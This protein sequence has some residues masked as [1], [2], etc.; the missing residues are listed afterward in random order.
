MQPDNSGERGYINVHWEEEKPLYY[1]SL[2][3]LTQEFGA[4]TAIGSSRGTEGRRAGYEMREVSSKGNLVSSLNSARSN[5][6]HRAQSFP[7]SNSGF[8]GPPENTGVSCSSALQILYK[9]LSLANSRPEQY[10]D[11]N[12]DKGRS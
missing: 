6:V 5:K 2:K 11:G 4:H 10:R 9:F 3:H 12:V 7:G 8:S 1:F